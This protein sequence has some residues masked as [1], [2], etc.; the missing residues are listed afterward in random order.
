VIAGAIVKAM[1]VGT[2]I[3]QERSTNSEGYYHFPGLAPGEYTAEVSYPKFQTKVL[4]H[5]V[6]QV[7]ETYTLDVFLE[8]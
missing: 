4:K 7:G 8:V 2:G 6:L 5:I 1:M 3:S